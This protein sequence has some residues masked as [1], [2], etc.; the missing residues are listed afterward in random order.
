MSKFG[1]DDSPVSM[2]IPAPLLVEMASICMLLRVLKVAS[3][4]KILDNFYIY[5]INIPNHYPEQK[6]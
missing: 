5:N 3:S 4:Q 2:Y 1:G 6:I